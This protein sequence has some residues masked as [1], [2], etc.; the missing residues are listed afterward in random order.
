[1]TVGAVVGAAT[2]WLLAATV[3]AARGWGRFHLL[4]L[5][6]YRIRFDRLLLRLPVAGS[7]MREDPWRR[8]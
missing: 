8:G 4:T 2:P 7:L 3:V 5:P 6:A 1:M